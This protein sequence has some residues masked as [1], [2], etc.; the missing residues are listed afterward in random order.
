MNE[1]CDK[2]GLDIPGPGHLCPDDLREIFRKI[3]AK[4]TIQHGDFLTYFAESFIRA[5]F[6]NFRLL[7]SVAMK[8]VEK[9]NL[10]S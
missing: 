3:A 4:E 10:A 6:S 9:Y 7:E 5:D 1:S 8:L 2:C